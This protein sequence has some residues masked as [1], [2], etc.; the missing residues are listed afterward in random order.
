VYGGAA[1]LPPSAP[2]GNYTPEQEQQMWQQLL[3]QQQQEQL[4]FTQRQEQERLQFQQQLQ[5]RL[6][7]QQA[8]R[9]LQLMSGN[10]VDA[11]VGSV[12]MQQQQQQ[13][14][15]SNN[16]L[17]ATVPYH[18][19]GVCSTSANEM[20]GTAAAPPAAPNGTSSPAL[21]LNANVSIQ[22][23]SLKPNLLCM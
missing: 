6:S 3:Q 8:Q 17:G 15:L 22:F 4:H 16:A 19:P 11:S 1:V 9:D 2:S 5:Q 20:E 7:N 13:Q 23:L 18:P 14:L 10:G 21:P 12:P